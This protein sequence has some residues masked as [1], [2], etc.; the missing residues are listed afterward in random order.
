MVLKLRLILMD[1]SHSIIRYRATN[2]A[3]HRLI[4]SL[5]AWWLKL[6]V[7]HDQKRTLKL[8]TFIF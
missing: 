5:P 1:Y 8:F 6:W 2:S 3:T 7:R 4:A